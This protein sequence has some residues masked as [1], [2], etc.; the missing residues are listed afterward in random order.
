MQPP[1]TATPAFLLD[2]VMHVRKREFDASRDTDRESSC[3]DEVI[4]T[5][6]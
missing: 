6:R 3:D 1:L 4:V 2:D 5:L